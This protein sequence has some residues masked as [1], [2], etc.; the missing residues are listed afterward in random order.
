MRGFTLIEI[1][2]VIG[3]FVVIAAMAVPVFGN[4]QNRAG[5]NS[6]EAE[7]RQLIRQARARSLAGLDGSAHGVYLSVDSGGGA[8][9]YEG[10]SYAS[11]T[12]DYDLVIELPATIYLSTTLIGNEIN[13]SQ[14]LGEP[15][16]YGTMTIANSASGETASIFVNELGVIE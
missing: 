10:N 7:I 11:R 14:G 9:L 12:R 13:F 16:T 1:L 5:L 4:W 15:N 3:I 6:A 2:V 8:V